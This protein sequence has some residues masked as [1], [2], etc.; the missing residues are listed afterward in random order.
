MNIKLFLKKL[1]RIIHIFFLQVEKQ[2]KI[3]C[4]ER[5]WGKTP[6]GI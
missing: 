1:F 6:H 5:M 2:E 4:M 3:G